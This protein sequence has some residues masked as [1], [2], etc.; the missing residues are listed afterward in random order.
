[1]FEFTFRSKPPPTLGERQNKMVSEIRRIDEKLK[2]LKLA[3]LKTSLVKLKKRNQSSQYL[4]S[5][6][7]SLASKNRADVEAHL[8]VE[9]T[10]S[11]LMLEIGLSRSHEY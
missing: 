4:Q 10:E 7:H 1:M 11:M 2:Y 9:S 6:E 3:S 8:L 5:R